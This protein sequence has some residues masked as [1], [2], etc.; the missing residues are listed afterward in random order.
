MHRAASRARRGD[1]ERV[2]HEQ[3][4]RRVARGVDGQRRHELGEAVE[5]EAGA[6]LQRGER[7][8]VL[9][10]PLEPVGVEHAPP[11]AGAAARGAEREPQREREQED[12][13][14]ERGGRR[15]GRAAAARPR[16]RRASSPAA[17]SA[18]AVAAGSQRTDERR[19]RQPELA[20]VVAREPQPGRDGRGHRRERGRRER[21]RAVRRHRPVMPSLPSSPH[22]AARRRRPA[23]R[24][25]RGLRL[26]AARELP[27]A[28]E[29]AA[30][31]P[32]T[33]PDGR[34]VARRRP[35]AAVP[36][37]PSRGS[38]RAAVDRRPQRRGRRRP[39]ERVVECSTPP[40]ARGPGARAAGVGPTHAVSDGGELP[41]RHRH[42]G[43]ALLVYHL[44]PALELI[45]RYPLP[46]SPYGIAVD[47][48]RGRLFVTQTARNQLTELRARR[49]PVAHRTATPRRASRTR[50]PS[51]RRTGRVF[52]TRQADGVL[53]LLD[54][55]RERTR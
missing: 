55:E 30:S 52:V 50:S 5:E 49:P 24:A 45:R 23:A 46:G 13:R 51:T 4:S 26:G 3:Q 25:R 7:G 47:T 14:G 9:V 40:R 27:P 42:R 32:S 28:A 31:P 2:H 15:R 41:V 39:R 54:P 44:R 20:P 16:R 10:R 1:A 18:Q 36:A 6:V 29:P 43:G 33:A 21:A 35:V 48:A 8:D 17:A 12:R 53:Q 22:G 38:A 34:L 19:V 11:V 37:A